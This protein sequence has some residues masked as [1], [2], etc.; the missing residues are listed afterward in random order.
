MSDDGSGMRPRT[1]SP[2]V[3]LSVLATAGVALLFAPVL[4]AL[5]RLATS[6]GHPAAATPYDVLSRFSEAV[7]ARWHRVQLHDLF[8]VS[9]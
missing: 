3:A 2:S 7:T 4:S 1:D 9:E 5:E 8:T 6:I